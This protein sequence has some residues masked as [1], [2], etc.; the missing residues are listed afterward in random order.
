MDYY[1]SQ[2]YGGYKDEVIIPGPT[3]GEKG[4]LITCCSMMLSYFNNNP[5]YPE[6]LLHW[7][8]KHNGLTSDGRLIWSKICEAAGGKL[9]MNTKPDSKPGE[10]TYGIRECKLSGQQHF[11]LDHPRESGKIIDPWDG[12][13][14][15]FNSQNY[16]GK[17]MFFMGKQ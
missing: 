11:V 13:V 5:L 12:K 2:R 14:K 1:Y 16:T 8:H 7:L 17:N 15:D 4:C 3:M 9:R 6:Q 10:V